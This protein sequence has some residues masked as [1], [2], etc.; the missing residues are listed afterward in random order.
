M[1]P[2]YA[3]D[4]KGEEEDDN[5]GKECKGEAMDTFSVYSFDCAH[6]RLLLILGSGLE[7][8]EKLIDGSIRD[9]LG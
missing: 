8:D 3:A 9:L 1:G 5:N 2:D 6:D 7:L 4:D